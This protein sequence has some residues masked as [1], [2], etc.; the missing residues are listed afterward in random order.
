MES[1]IDK[2]HLS[3]PP[4][5]SIDPDDESVAG[6]IAENVRQ[7]VIYNYHVIPPAEIASDDRLC[8]LLHYADVLQSFGYDRANLHGVLT[9]VCMNTSLGDLEPECDRIVS[10]LFGEHPDETEERRRTA[11]ND[12]DIPF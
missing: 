1:P 5:E 7:R 11:G 2:D 12:N 9:E 10:M 3:V 6:L 4:S 8:K